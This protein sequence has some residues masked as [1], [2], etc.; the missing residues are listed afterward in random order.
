MVDGPEKIKGGV[1]VDAGTDASPPSLSGTERA[2]AELTVT[3]DRIREGSLALAEIVG[4][5]RVDRRGSGDPTTSLIP[6][7]SFLLPPLHVSTKQGNKGEVDL[8]LREEAAGVVMME[9]QPL[10]A[11]TATAPPPGSAEPAGAPPAVVSASF[12]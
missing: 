7:P 4:S 5:S 8:H 6:S 10:Q 2:S 9:S 1:R 3:G 11:P 12:L